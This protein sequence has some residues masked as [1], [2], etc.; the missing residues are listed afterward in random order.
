[1]I[2]AEPRATLTFDSD[3]LIWEASVWGDNDP[4]VLVSERWTPHGTEWHRGPLWD[5]T[6]PTF[7]Y[8]GAASMEPIR[9]P[10]WWRLPWIVKMVMSGDGEEAT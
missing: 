8:A 1:M 5:E 2:T 4:A 9:G 7:W 6:E 3:L 10:D